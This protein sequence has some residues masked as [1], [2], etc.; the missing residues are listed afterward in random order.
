[1]PDM[2]SQTNT[3][4]AWFQQYGIVLLVVGVVALLVFRSLRPWVHRA[5]VKTLHAQAQA[6]DG[7]GASLAEAD[8]RVTT[9]ETLLLRILRG[10][11]I[12]GIVAILLGVFDL[13]SMLTGLGLWWRRSRSPARASA[14][15]EVNQVETGKKRVIPD[16][17]DTRRNRNCRQ[18]GAGAEGLFG[19]FDKPLSESDMAQAR[20]TVK[21]TWPQ[22]EHMVGNDNPG[23]MRVSCE[24]PFPDPVGR[25]RDRITTGSSRRILDQLAPSFVEDH[26]IH[27]GEDRH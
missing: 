2:S 21:S 4:I 15:C 23:Q 14:E 10:L 27:A 5:L 19:N 13:W 17:S 7:D 12:L 25:F 26:A 9:L 24:S 8:R 3:L 11:V 22:A 6:Q 16:R 20:A 1:M 18:S